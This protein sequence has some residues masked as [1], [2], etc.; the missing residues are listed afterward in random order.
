[1]S[2]VF[3]ASDISYSMLS[4]FGCVSGVS[5]CG[6]V[7]STCVFGILGRTDITFTSTSRLSLSHHLDPSDKDFHSLG[8]VPDLN[9]NLL[10]E[11]LE[12]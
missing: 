10:T 8:R 5:Y 9:P 12:L 3:C 4:E 7:Y 1:M 11:A 6:C 2:C